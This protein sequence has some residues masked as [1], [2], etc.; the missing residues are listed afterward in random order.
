MPMIVCVDC[1][2]VNATV[3]HLT[4]VVFTWTSVIASWHVLLHTQS[5]RCLRDE[6]QTTKATCPRGCVYGTTADCVHFRSFVAALSSLIGAS[7]LVC[8]LTLRLTCL[9]Y[10]LW[11]V[12]FGISSWSEK[13]MKCMS[14]S[15]SLSTSVCPVSAAC[16][17]N[18]FA[19]STANGMDSCQI[20][21]NMLV[22]SGL[23]FTELHADRIY[24]SSAFMI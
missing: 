6:I 5:V 8:Q 14:F 1:W 4:V 23:P 11:T 3:L 10:W 12:T 24:C 20:F 2:A 21:H 22:S 15:M 7:P 13:I 16:R 18:S 17:F 19:K 9:M